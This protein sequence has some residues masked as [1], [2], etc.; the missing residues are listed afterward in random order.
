[1]V[2]GGAGLGAAVR[3]PPRRACGCCPTRPTRSSRRSTR[4]CGRRTAPPRSST[5]T[6]PRRAGR[7]RPRSRWRPSAASGRGGGWRS[8]RPRSAACSASG[9][10]AAAGSPTPAR[11][12]GCPTWCSPSRRGA[13]GAAARL[14]HG[15]R[16]GHAGAP[17][18]VARHVTGVGAR[19]VRARRPR[20]GRARGRAGVGVARRHGVRRAGGAGGAA[21]AVLRRLPGRL[22]AARAAVPGPGVRARAGAGPRRATTRC[23]CS[24]AWSAASGTRSGPASGCAITV[25]PLGRLT[26]RQRAALEDEVERIGAIVE[27]R[28]RARRWGR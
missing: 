21:A 19:A 18:P 4:R 28:A 26:R 27:A 3:R 5:R 14:P 25:E 16:P 15:V 23:C 7:G 1:M 24:T 6:S 22:A 17:G 13:A 11:A 12:G 20:G 2:A 9:P 8:V 10:T